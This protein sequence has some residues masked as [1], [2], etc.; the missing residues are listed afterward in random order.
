M[1]TDNKHIDIALLTRYLA[2]ETDVQENSSVEAWVAASDENRKEFVSLKKA[3]DTLEKTNPAQEIDI[4]SEWKHNQILIRQKNPAARSLP[5]YR[6]VQIAASVVILLGISLAAAR[7]LSTGRVKSGLLETREIMLADGSR[8]TLNAGSTLFYNHSFN[9]KDRIV[10]LQGEGY[11]EVEKNPEKPF[12]IQL[13]MAEIKVLGTS[14]NVKAYKGAENI[15]VTVTEG[16]V[17]LY[18]T[19]EEQ[20][21]VIATVGEKAEYIKQ[22]KAVKKTVNSNQN[23]LAW[24]TKIANFQNDSLVNVISTLKNMYHKDFILSNEAL[25]ACT[26]T[27]RFENKDMESVLHIL[28]STLDITIEQDHDRFVIS[29]TGC[30]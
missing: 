21:Q 26:I 22:L 9:S 8:V 19:D 6:L 25:S 3:W 17:S 2:A 5:L 27:A 18:D 29:G 28:E 12:I 23:Y 30:K 14:F 11:F 13:G 15:E 4:E 1:E 10:R 24:K 20:K 16:R 7:Y